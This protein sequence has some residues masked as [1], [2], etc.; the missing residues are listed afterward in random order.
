M[1]IMDLAWTRHENDTHQQVEA[2]VIGEA[3]VLDGIVKAPEEDDD[4]IGSPMTQEDVAIMDQLDSIVCN[5]IDKEI[6]AAKAS[7]GA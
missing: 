7:R 4:A 5:I 3:I 1:T 2:H 6:S